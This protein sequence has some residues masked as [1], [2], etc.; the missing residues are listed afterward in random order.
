MLFKS[1]LSLAIVA[2]ICTLA[3]S[4]DLAGVKCVV[5][6][7]H[8]ASADSAIEYK[9]GKVYFCCDDCVAKFKDELKKE[10][11]A[12]ATKANH[13]LVLTGQYDQKGCP[14]SGKETSTDYVAKVGGVEVGFCCGGCQG[15]VEK[16]EGLA[17]K[18]EL[19][20][21]DVP[22][23]RAFA[24]KSDEVNLEGVKCMM[25]PGKD[26]AAKFSVEY[27]GG[28]VYFCCNGCKGKF[29]KDPEQ[30]VAK[31]NHQLVATGQ[32][33]QVA[34]PFSGQEVDEDQVSEVAGI[35]VKLCCGNCKAKVD[36]A[37]GDQQLE[38]VFGKTAFEKGFGEEEK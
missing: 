11:N 24:A 22:F 20:F 30:Y 6:G 18:A 35:K 2:T 4:Q 27:G 34:C 31:A 37:E 29:G 19:V 32:V 16:A 15:K 36:Q 5:N 7:D 21:A 25:M 9:A 10:E 17:A 12:F 1:T 23:E 26:V 28:K 33:K 8:Q 14:M 38:L 13:Q 3:A